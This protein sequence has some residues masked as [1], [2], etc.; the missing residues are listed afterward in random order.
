[1]GAEVDFRGMFVMVL[2]EVREAVGAY[3]GPGTALPTQ[4]LLGGTILIV[5]QFA[6]RNISEYS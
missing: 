6:D 1:M 3:G 2:P 4:A 5:I